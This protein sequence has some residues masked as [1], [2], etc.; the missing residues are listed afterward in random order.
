MIMLV[1]LVGG[2]CTALGVILTFSGLWLAA[3]GGAWFYIFSG[4][5]MT[6]IGI[7]LIKK[8][9]L[10]F[11]LAW[12]LLSIS[13]VWSLWEVGIDFWQTVPR[14]LTYLA[15]TLIVCALVPFL[16]ERNGNKPVSGKVGGGLAAL[17]GCVFA[18]FVASMFSPHAQVT[19]SGPAK[20]IDEHA[21]DNFGNDWRDW[22][23]NTSGQRFAQFTQINKN[24]VN[25]LKVAWT[26]RTGDLAVSGAEYQVTP[27]KVNDTVYL[28]TPLNKVIAIDPVTGKEK[29]RFD[30]KVLINDQNKDWKRCR[31]VSYTDEQGATVTD[32]S[33]A[34]TTQTLT[35]NQSADATCRKR[36][37]STTIDARLFA[38]DADSGTL[39]ENFGDHGYVNLLDNLGEMEPGHYYVTAAPLVAGGVVV[40]GGKISDN[41]KVG[42]PSGV[43]RAYDSQTGK[44][45]W[46]FDPARGGEDTSPLPQGQIY[47]RE[48]PNFWG[49][50]AYDPELKLVYFPTGNQTPDFWTGNR[51]DYSNKYGD[52]IVALDIK[53]GHERWHFNTAHIDQ[54][55]YDNTSQPLLYDLPG[56][57]GTKIPL[58][59]QLTKRGQVFVLDRRDGKPVFPVE[60][61]KVQTD[62]MPGMQVSPTQPYSAI[63]VGTTPLTEAD[64]WG[65]TPFDQLYCR[66]QFRGMRWSGEWT[67][68][69]DKQRTLIYP[70]YYGGMNW[71][72]GAIDPSTGTLIVND[73]RIAQWGQFI[74]QDEARRRGLKPGAE[75]E[76]SEQKG[77]PWGVVRSI[78][79]SP[80]GVP[81]FKPP[82]G[83]MSAIDLTTGKTRWQ[84]P[85]GSI[86][87]AAVH[88]VVP[89]TYIPLGMPTMG[90]PLVTKGG[91]TFFFGSLDYY[92]RAFDNDTGKE[93]WKGRLPVGGQ[94]APMTYVGRD[95]K[96]YIVLVDGGATRTG[97]N[98]N[99]GDYVIAYSLP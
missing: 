40:V 95:N 99:R 65:A 93:L 77:T 14:V 82:F 81:C 10:A 25:K 52:A 31:G 30:P 6:C 45:L 87:D 41:L 50:A 89:H 67:P 55:D 16:S 69:S 54:F 22:G 42:E 84:V 48:T 27:I 73:I 8:S 1:P 85:L 13:V 46:A 86:Q 5:L 58:V 61:Q 74:K 20:V 34:D 23:R 33:L 12:L 75:G 79:L 57:N 4:I 21:G 80:L 26:F 92:I 35:A 11:Y 36:I 29:W 49:T 3:I 43:V 90:G 68:L 51:H 64:M 94:G 17:L 53:T 83:T 71:G 98:K 96:Q 91:L 63:S 18:T 62:V 70:G 88:G 56:K 78:F 37:I 32:L 97:S 28:C 2:V 66:I 59:I 38:L 15:V 72:G 44:V 47:T 19:S 9:I 76:Y 39:C 7:S 60:E 24:N